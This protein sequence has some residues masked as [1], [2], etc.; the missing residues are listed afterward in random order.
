[1]SNQRRRRF[2]RPNEKQRA[3]AVKPPR[4]RAART[5]AKARSYDVKHERAYVED[6]ASFRPI[7]RPR[8]SDW[9][10]EHEERGQTFSSF[11][12]RAMRCEPHGHVNVIELV[13]IGSFDHPSAPSLPL[14]TRF[15]SIFFGCTCRVGKRLK[16]KHV[17]HDAR[18]GDEDQLQLLVGSVFEALGRRKTTRDVLC[19]VAVTM[20]DLYPKEDWNFVFG[21]A[22]AMDAV[23]VFS[24]A[25]YT[26]GDSF[27][28]AWKGCSDRAVAEYEG[29]WSS[30]SAVSAMRIDDEDISATKIR[31]SVL[32]R[33]AKVLAHET[34]HLFGIRHCIYYE[35][36]MCGCNHLKEFDKRPC[37]SSEP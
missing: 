15:L 8:G 2:R 27:P 25:R 6:N 32:Y 16:V 23:G 1:M 13:P 14:L 7:D 18:R 17:M 11:T 22:R 5:S 9:L 24:F 37:R 29:E 33:S 30:S 35:C 10:V 34:G 28:V 26:R 36:L 4:R 3:E 20:I 19:K 31:S 21:M 12:K